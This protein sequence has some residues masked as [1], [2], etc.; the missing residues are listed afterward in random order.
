MPHPGRRFQL[1]GD[2]GQPPGDGPADVTSPRPRS[3]PA[4][5]GSPSRFDERLGATS[6]AAA[7]VM[8]APNPAAGPAADPAP[9]APSPSPAPGR[10]RRRRPGRVLVPLAAACAGL[11]AGAAAAPWLPGPGTLPGSSADTARRSA[12]AVGTVPSGSPSATTP[13]AAPGPAE[14]LPAAPATEADLPPVLSYRV[15]GALATLSRA[16][17][18]THPS[19]IPLQ[20]APQPPADGCGSSVAGRYS[21][22]DGLVTAGVV[23]LTLPADAGEVDPGLLRLPGVERPGQVYADRVGATLVVTGAT[24]ATGV[25]AAEVRS[26]AA[27]VQALVAAQVRLP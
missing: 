24:G 21:S 1:P 6:G 18:A 20:R 17:V 16:E 10:A 4:Q 27:K 7:A 5:G 12:S 25:P 11:L 2:Y 13:P 19:C 8:P 22:E 9:V 3:V 23:L 26:H 15:D 14:R